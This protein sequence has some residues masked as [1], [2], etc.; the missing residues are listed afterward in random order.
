M[1]HHM[2]HPRP[3]VF[4][5]LLLASLVL[6]T[7]CSDSKDDASVATPAF[8]ADT[9]YLND[10]DQGQSVDEP[11]VEDAPD[12]QIDSTAQD[13]EEKQYKD[14]EREWTAERKS[15][16]ILGKSRDKARDLA[17]Q[18]Q[19]STQPSNGIAVTYADEEYA[20]AGG[21]A[22]DMPEDWQM[23]VPSNGRFAEMYIQNQ[24]GNASVAFTKET[25]SPTQVRRLLESSITDTFSSRTKAR[26]STK[27]VRGFTVTI[28]D[29]KGTY[30]DPSAKGMTNGSPFYAIHAVVI[31]LPTTKV[32]IKLFGPQDTVEQ[33]I[34]KFDAMIEKMYEK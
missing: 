13:E 6:A 12:E 1:T 5:S 16:S 33:N 21:F 9:S 2:T 4:A 27:V 22:W 29:L 10:L 8:E 18:I 14:E 7:G 25:S 32:L 34:G 24:L 3:I 31:E 30:I 23:A 17:T 19:D 11:V 20:Q 28:F 26:T 15:K